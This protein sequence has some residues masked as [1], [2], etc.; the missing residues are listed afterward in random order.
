MPFVCSG[1]WCWGGAARGD[2]EKRLLEFC[3]PKQEMDRASGSLKPTSEAAAP[4]LQ[5]GRLPSW[6]LSLFLVS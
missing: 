3:V 1:P 2:A 4:P 6:R 5:L